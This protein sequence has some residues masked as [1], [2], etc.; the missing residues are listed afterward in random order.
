[1][2]LCDFDRSTVKKNIQKEKDTKERGEVGKLRKM[3]S[4]FS[5]FASNHLTK[6]ENVVI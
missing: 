6:D 2:V 1:V 4:L 3:V 5:F